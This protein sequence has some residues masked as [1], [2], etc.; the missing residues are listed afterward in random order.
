MADL[1][2]SPYFS[3]YLTFLTETEGSVPYFYCDSEHL[4]TIGVGYLVDQV[5]A[6]DTVGQQLARDLA[7]RSDIRLNK[8]NGTRATQQEAANDWLAVKNFGRTQIRLAS[9]YAAIATLRMDSASIR[10]LTDAKVRSYLNDLYTKRT[11]VIEHDARVAM[12]LLD[13]RYNPAGVAIYGTDT[14][15]VQMWAAL[16]PTK[17]SYDAARACSL[18]ESI[19]ATRGN[20]RYKRRHARRVEWMYQGLYNVAGQPAMQSI[21]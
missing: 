19:W 4:V 21:P 5:G 8:A 10:V 11:Y 2:T 18:F 1:R 16:D 12:A 15:V 14:R 7:A 6:P 13:T 3:D 17:A 20:D 9:E